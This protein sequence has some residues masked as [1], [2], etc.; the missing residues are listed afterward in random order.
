[1][2]GGRDS[3]GVLIWIQPNKYTMSYE[4]TVDVG[5]KSDASV[6][7]IAGLAITQSRGLFARWG[8][9][10][11]SWSICRTLNNYWQDRI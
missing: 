9:A 3:R 6:P 1:M 10:L 4:S 7:K 8:L 2:L 11:M 5:P